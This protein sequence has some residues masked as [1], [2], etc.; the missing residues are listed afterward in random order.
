MNRRKEQ[1][2][3]LALAVRIA[4]EQIHREP[5][6]RVTNRII[7]FINRRMAHR[8]YEL[9]ERPLEAHDPADMA[10]ELWSAAFIGT[11][12]TTHI[13]LNS[14][15]MDRAALRAINQ[16][17]LVYNAYAVQKTPP[18]PLGWDDPQYP[19]SGRVGDYPDPQRQNDRN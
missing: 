2:L 18:L 10:V 13:R 9:L 4:F 1:A 11:D 19:V 5:S 14:A 7:A 15:D 3:A 6:T 12:V 8:A 17:V 16:V